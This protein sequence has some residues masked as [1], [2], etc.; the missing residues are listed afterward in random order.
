M[1]KILCC[2]FSLVFAMTF[3]IESNASGSI[4]NTNTLINKFDNNR[5]SLERSANDK[6]NLLIRSISSS[7]GANMYP[8][9]YCGAYFDGKS[10]VVLVKNETSKNKYDY[11]IGS[12]N[13]RYQVAKFSLN[14]LN[15]TYNVLSSLFDNEKYG[16]NVLAMYQKENVVEVTASSNKCLTLISEYLK[17]NGINEAMIRYKIGEPE[18]IPDYTETDSYNSI[19]DNSST[20]SHPFPL[21]MLPFL[22]DPEI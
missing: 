14:E 11:L 8:E 22:R 13:V 2:L 20:F 10:M 4:I 7:N 9:E 16:M 15:F 6:Y 1:K 19:T 3:C 17:K 21:R 12:S 5:M 18:T